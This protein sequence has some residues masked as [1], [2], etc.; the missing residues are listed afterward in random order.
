[1]KKILLLAGVVAAMASCT[2]N[3]V[4]DVNMDNPNLINFTTYTGSATKGADVT[5]ENIV[6]GNVGVYAVAD[7]GTD[8]SAYT[9][10]NTM[11][12]ATTNGY[13]DDDNSGTGDTFSTP[14]S[15][16]WTS[17]A[18]YYW[19]IDPATVY[20]FYAYYPFTDVADKGAQITNAGVLTDTAENFTLAT[21][22][23][24]QIDIL[25]GGNTTIAAQSSTVMLTL[26]H[27]LSKV[28]FQ[29]GVK[30]EVDGSAIKVMIHDISLSGI[31]STH[32]GLD[33][34]NK[35]LADPTAAQT[36]TTAYTY[37]GANTENATFDMAAIDETYATD[38]TAGTNTWTPACSLEGSSPYYWTLDDSG[39]FDVTD[40][41]VS[42][43]ATN[44]IG[45]DSKKI[46]PS[47]FS[48]DAYDS[49]GSEAVD[50]FKLLPQTLTADV[51]Q[52][53]LTYS[54]T[55]NGQDI[56]GET[57]DDYSFTVTYS[58]AQGGAAAA[59]YDVTITGEIPAIVDGE[60]TFTSVDKATY[61]AYVQIATDSESSQINGTYYA[62]V[63]EPTIN[64]TLTST[65]IT[66]AFDLR[67]SN[68][69]AWAAGSS[70]LYTITFIA[71][72]GGIDDATRIEFDVVASDWGAID[73]EELN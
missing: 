21:T 26:N 57:E 13:N 66:K 29:I 62:A 49:T 44:L 4:V 51:Q 73:D 48:I 70:Y 8:F 35:K 47:Y 14:V 65:K 7:T 58:E 33:L 63:S 42:E 36:Y 34:Y 39:V 37:G 6:D 3:E 1:M 5:S 20:D 19:P 54:I 40:A 38:G 17:S 69:T 72:D 18:S 27:M 15:G 31:A 11:L 64:T 61:E 59:D 32:G 2:K 50:A 12:S 10:P 68:V 45:T 28:D 16:Q 22:A 43:G 9:I 60:Q 24:D 67:T 25:A 56:V 71:Q 55:Q 53:L 52:V 46:A 41:Y 23:A 30:S